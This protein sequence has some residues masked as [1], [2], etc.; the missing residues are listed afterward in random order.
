[1]SWSY[2]LVWDQYQAD[3]IGKVTKNK[4]H[5]K[6]VGPIW[7]SDNL[8]SINMPFVPIAVFDIQP[9]RESLYKS[10]AIDFDFYT[11]SN[12]IQFLIDIRDVAKEMNIKFVVKR[13]REITKLAHPKYRSFFKEL[14][15]CYNYT[16]ISSN[17]SARKV[18][19]NCK[20][21]IS[22][23]FTSTALIGR[24]CNK[25]SIYY[26]PFSMLC[27]DD[28]AAHGIEILQGRKELRRWLCMVF[29]GNY[30]NALLHN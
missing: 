13:K 16:S 3:F 10:Y 29:E 14:D 20:A 6:V 5:V 2:Y 11:P 22:M 15:T 25:F 27:K 24:D 7:F 30:S 4:N 1:M 26:D 18:I 12:A 9:V 19:Q 8:S 23:P 17:A 28:P 21:V